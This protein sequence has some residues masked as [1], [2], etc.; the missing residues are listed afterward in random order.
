MSPLTAAHRPDWAA[1]DTVLLD[2]DGTLLD[3]AFDNHFWRELIPAAY[4]AARGVPTQEAAA[5]L[6]ERFRAWEGTLNWYC[7]EHWSRELGLD[8]AALKRNAAARVAW[9]PGVQRALARLRERGKRLVLLTNAH[10]VAL[11]IK[12]EQTGVT[13]FM[14]AVFSSHTFGVPKEDARFW[15]GVRR[16]EP[17]ALERSMF[18]DDS[19]AVLRAAQRA[20][21]RYIYGIRRPDS[22]DTHRE[23][24]DVP[25]VDSIAELALSA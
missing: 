13:A 12:D 9:L 1:I 8:V 23:H 6:A 2:L 10:P 11:A 5:Q 17:F 24:V 14:D 3:L 7:V 22:G 18:V 19:P 15:E 20:G 16:L 25:A 21:I 4:A